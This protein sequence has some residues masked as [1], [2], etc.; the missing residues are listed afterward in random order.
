MGQVPGK[1]GAFGDVGYRYYHGG[2]HKRMKVI[3][4]QNIHSRPNLGSWTCCVGFF[5]G[6]DLLWFWNR[7]FRW[8]LSQFVSSFICV[9]LD[10]PRGQGVGRCLQI[11]AWQ[12]GQTVLGH[13]SEATNL[14]TWCSPPGKAHPWAKYPGHRRLT[15]AWP[16][17]SCLEPE[18]GCSVESQSLVCV[19]PKSHL[20]RPWGYTAGCSKVFRDTS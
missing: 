5:W 3:F 8:V 13:I 16:S 2:H 17:P 18:A 4:Q 19:Y 15:S 14:Q 12:T 9:G 11:G 1:E 10:C 7:F 20:T 6:S